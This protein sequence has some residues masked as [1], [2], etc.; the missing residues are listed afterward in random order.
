[1]PVLAQHGIPGSLGEEIKMGPSYQS[2]GA[3]LAIRSIFL[4]LNPRP[5]SKMVLD[6]GK[7]KSIFEENGGK[8]I[9]LPNLFPA[10]RVITLLHARV[11]TTESCPLETDEH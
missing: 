8:S 2:Y 1:M 3:A 7:G 9:L 5:F 6:S 10:I 11:P 4:S